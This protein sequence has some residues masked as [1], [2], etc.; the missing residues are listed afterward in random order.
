[1]C[2]FQLTHFDDLKQ[3]FLYLMRYGPPSPLQGESSIRLCYCLLFLKI[4]I[5][6]FMNLNKFAMKHWRIWGGGARSSRLNFLYFH[7]V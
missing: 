2:Y 5:N 7:D 3:N 4:F 1:M 6:L